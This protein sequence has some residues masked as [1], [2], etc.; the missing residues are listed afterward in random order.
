MSPTTALPKTPEQL[1]SASILRLRLHSPFFAT[2]AMMAPVVFTHAIDTAAT[3][4]ESLFFNPD[5]LCRLK[6]SQRDGLLAHELLH[7]ALLHV[8]RLGTRN[9]LL[10][11]VAVDI[12]VNGM[13][14]AEQHLDLPEGSVRD[15][16]LE[17]LRAE[18]VY[19]VILKD[20]NTVSRHLGLK[21]LRPDLREAG[22]KHKGP[23]GN[24][25]TGD[26]QTPRRNHGSATNGGNT[27]PGANGSTDGGKQATPMDA[28]TRK[29]LERKWNEALSRAAAAAM[30]QGKFPA[31]LARQVGSLL[32][33]QVDWRTRL[34]Q[35][36][37]RTPDDFAGFDRRMLWNELYLEQ[38]EGE[39][40]TVDVCVDTSGSV[41]EAGLRAFLSEVQGIVNAYHKI[42][43]RLYYADAGCHGPYPLEKSHAIPR[44]V[45][46]GGTD[47]R[48]FFQAVQS[49]PPSNPH[50]TRLLVYL[51]DGYGTFPSHAPEH[52]C[53]WVIAPGG[54]TDAQVPFGEV[55]RMH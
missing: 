16:K 26:G 14:S 51:T 41:D 8:P 48:P 43:V 4:G 23:Q 20:R 30:T 34:W 47:F 38:L 36:L 44:P 54:V 45:G 25:S 12:V 55:L 21:D 19:E 52:P 22:D 5:F 2:L 1:L 17:H 53:L 3:D 10:W 33:P 40:V 9:P 31:T 39:S 27:K 28:A 15:P 32:T 6:P 46:G 18:E 50:G 13:V 35:Y 49:C 11:N 37:V 42:E 24:K 7:A 29:Q